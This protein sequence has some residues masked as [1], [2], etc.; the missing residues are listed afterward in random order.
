MNLQGS[1]PDHTPLYLDK[2]EQK[3]SGVPEHQCSF[4]SKK[5][6]ALV[7]ALDISPLQCFLLGC[8]TDGLANTGPGPQPGEE[9]AQQ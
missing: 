6:T 4:S 3:S 1:P 7:W 8:R 9:E 2:H 5:H